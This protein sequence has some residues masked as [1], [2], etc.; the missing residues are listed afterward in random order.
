ME[1]KVQSVLKL[2]E[3]DGDS[4]ARRAEM[5]YKK[6]PELIHF[7]EESYRAYRALAERYDHISTELQNA[8]NAIASV[9]PDQV[10]FIDDEDDVAPPRSPRAP[11]V[12]RKLPEGFKPPNSPKPPPK[13]LRSVTMSAPKRMFSKKAATAETSPTAP[14]SRLSKKEVLQEVDKLQKQIL[15]L[16]TVKEFVKSSY[17]NAITRYWETEEHIKELQD[18][19]FSLEE[20][21]GEVVVIDDD[22]ARHVMAEA[23]LKACQETLTHL[24]EKQER[25]VGKSTIESKKVKEIKEKFEALLREFQY[26]PTILSEPRAK[27]DTK[28][29]AETKDLDEDVERMTQKRQELQKLQ[30]KIKEHFE[31]DSHSSFSVTEMVEKVDDL[32]NKAVSLETAVSSQAALVKRL[33]AEANELQSQIRILEN[34]KASLINDK[35]NLNNKLRAMEEK[36]HGVEDLNQTVESQNINLQTHFTEACCNLDH[37]SKRVQNMWPDEEEVVDFS[38]RERK[39]SDEAEP[40]NEV[41]GEDALNQDNI[42]LK[43]INSDK[44]IKVNELQVTGSVEDDV[45]SENKLMVTG[46]HKTEEAHQVEN[47]LPSKLKEQEE[48][49][50]LGNDD[51]K[52]R[53]VLSISAGEKTESSPE[54]SGNQQEIDAKPKSSETE[55]SL[56]VEGLV[57]ATAKED[58]LDWQHLFTNGLQ[59]K[60]KVLLTE[61][62]KT[63]KNYKDVKKKLTELENKKQDS[64]FD[65]SLQLKELKHALALK[66]EEIRFLRQKLALLQK[67]LGENEEVMELNSPMPAE[68]PNI[69]EVLKIEAPDSTS[70]N[71]EKFRII[72]DLLLEE[73]LEFWLKF[74]TNFN[75]IQKFETTIKDLVIEASKLDEQVTSSECSAT[76]KYSLKTDARPIYKHLEEIQTELTVWLAKSAL[77][78]EEQKSRFSSL[79]DIQEEI[80]KALKASAED[81]EFKFTSFQAAKFQGEIMNM[82]Q[83]NNRVADELQ[84]GLDHVTTQQLQVQK[85]LA[86]LNQQFGLSTSNKPQGSHL[87]NADSQHRVPLRSFLFGDKQKKQ[88]HSIFSYMTHGAPRKY[89]SRPKTPM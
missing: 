9:F 69:D 35:T 83:E 29:T 28:D 33:R 14:K 56:K 62:T 19:V 44:E 63:L 37:L 73:N 42:L 70:A 71:E 85:V 18:R 17:D 30:E 34:D 87:T 6:R 80:T 60:E 57:L 41:K 74:S 43:D 31:V 61:Y 7:V 65:T 23:A 3:E 26:N 25:S 22:E 49:L 82:K 67:S 13:D 5:Y 64:Q 10:P 8:N 51:E 4:F 54:S 53:D 12:P 46:T 76:M 2:I 78:K 48:T 24:Q 66:D 36:M 59:D 20:E 40:K 45:K 15:E 16:Q 81:D 1:E 89:C 84:T 47:K 68:K 39:S 11:G 21:I 58:K 55:N 52:A 50:N 77:L 75:K 38:Q 86:K 32:V 79:C 88:K 27:R 72:I